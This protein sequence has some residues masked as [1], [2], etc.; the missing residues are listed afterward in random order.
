MM[1]PLPM[2]RV[3]AGAVATVV[4]VSGCVQAAYDRTVVYRVDVSAVPNVSTVGLRGGDQP[5]SWRTDTPMVPVP[6]SA[7]LYTATVTT[8]TGRLVTE[9][10]F[11]VNGTFEFSDAQNQENRKVP[12]PRTTTGGDTLIYRAVFNTR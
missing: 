9:V 12:L 6:D 5:L 8:R 11:V 7:G 10:K 1:R 2:F 4:A 3:L